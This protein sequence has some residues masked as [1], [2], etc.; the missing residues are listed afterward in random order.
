MELVVGFA[1][2]S[3]EVHFELLAA[4]GTIQFCLNCFATQRVYRLP[5]YGVQ[6]R[7]IFVH[8]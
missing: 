2:S 5:F 6:Q 1:F 8:G 7:G 4:P 3:R